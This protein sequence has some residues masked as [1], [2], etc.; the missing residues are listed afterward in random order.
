MKIIYRGAEAILYSEKIDGRKIVVKERI[1]KGYRIPVLD[2]RIIKRR[3][4][5]EE[6]LLNRAQRN[7]V[8]VPKVLGVESSKIFMEFVDGKKVKDVLNNLSSDDRNNVYELIGKEIASLH[9]ANI[10]HGD[11]TTSNFILTDK[12]LFVVDFGLGKYSERVEDQAV[13]LYVLYEALKAA[14]F[15]YL[16]HAWQ[17]ILKSYSYS[18]SNAKTVLNRIEKI[19]KRRRYK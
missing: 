13:D 18:Y 15:K 11:L 19:K 5:R 17:N 4:K 3:T 6:S 16:N 8:T 1:K 7:G 9:N 2:D 12:K 14:H 10:I